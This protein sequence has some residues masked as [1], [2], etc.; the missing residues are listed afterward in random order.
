MSIFY[1]IIFA[2]LGLAMG[3]LQSHIFSLVDFIKLV[4]EDK[5]TCVSESGSTTD[6]DRYN[7]CIACRDIP[8]IHSKW[9]FEWT[10]I[11]FLK[12]KKTCRYICRV[13]TRT[14]PI[15]LMGTNGMVYIFMYIIKGFTL[16]TFI[17][18]L[19]ATAL[20]SISVI[21]WETQYIPAE[22]N[23][24]ICILGLIRLFT[25]N[26]DNWLEYVIGLF[27]VSGFLLLINFIGSKLMKVDQVMGG[28][29]IKLMAAAGLLLGWKLNLLALILGCVLGTMFHLII[30]AI[31]KGD[32]VLAFGP[33]LSMGIFIAMI[34]GQQ[35][36]SWYLS[37][38]G[39]EKLV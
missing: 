9:L 38:A 17:Y 7:S 15:L 10:Y 13:S 34:W 35:L 25:I 28:G 12:L 8:I 22:F 19:C 26:R 29:D 5:L 39:F 21:D 33:Y 6:C 14:G 2:L 4:D 24:F 30:M 3:A 36:V 32:H 20:I 11:C 16:D 27:A 1:I 18:C 37:I 31:K 23:V